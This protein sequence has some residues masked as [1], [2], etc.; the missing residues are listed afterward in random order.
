MFLMILFV[1]LFLSL[2]S[3][4]SEE[5]FLG[6]SYAEKLFFRISKIY[7]EKLLKKST[8]SKFASSLK[9]CNE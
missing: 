5:N 6:K 1:G 9:V 4:K 3:C 7:W 2:D 8:F